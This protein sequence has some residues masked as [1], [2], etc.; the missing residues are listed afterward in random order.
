MPILLMLVLLLTPAVLGAQEP[1]RPHTVTVSATGMIE[2]APDRA[3]LLVAVESFAATAQE[4]SRE[5]ARKME[6]LLAAL[7]R[8]GLTGDRVRTVAYSLEPEYDFSTDGG[9]RRPGENRLIGYR[10]RNM[11]Q[12]TI[13]DVERVGPIIDAAIAAGA[14]RVAG[15]S[16]QLRDPEAARQDAIRQAIGKARAEAEAIAAAI[17]RPLG[18]ALSVVTNGYGPPRPMYAARA[19]MMTTTPIEPGTLE[20]SASVTV[21]YGL[22]P[23]ND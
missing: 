3:V 13:D 22:G 16:F 2:R 9:P 11:V 14:D 15:L 7:R 12:V 18:P 5:N 10:A 8:A 19:D 23:D 17:G 20:I 21:V 6:A 4:A 1:T